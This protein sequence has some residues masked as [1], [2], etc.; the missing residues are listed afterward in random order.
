MVRDLF[1]ARQLDPRLATHEWIADALL[2]KVPAGGYPP[3]ASGVLDADTVW[4]HLC[5]QHLGLP[6]GRPD[7]LAL[8]QLEISAAWRG[9]HWTSQSQ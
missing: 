5:Q 6:D 7:A 1:R 9:L 2:Q 8:I 4:M 3:V